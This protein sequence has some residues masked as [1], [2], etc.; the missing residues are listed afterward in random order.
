MAKETFPYGNDLNHPERWA[1]LANTKSESWLV[2]Y[3]KGA[4][5]IVGGHTFLFFGKES[6]VA[7]SA[8]FR[9]AGLTAGYGLSNITKRATRGGG[10][11]QRYPGSNQQHSDPAQVV[12]AFEHSRDAVNT[13]DWHYEKDD[14]GSAHQIYRTLAANVSG[15][16]AL[17]PFSS[18]D[19]NWTYGA[20]SGVSVEA[21]IG[22]GT[23]YLADASNLFTEARVI[24]I[25][26]EPTLLSAS[27]GSMQGFWFVDK[28]YSLWTERAY[29]KTEEYPFRA[30]SV[31]PYFHQW[32]SP[33]YAQAQ[34]LSRVQEQDRVLNDIKK[35]MME[36]PTK[37][38][39]PDSDY[40][41]QEIIK[42][43]E[44]LNQ[45]ARAPESNPYLPWIAAEHREVFGA[46]RWGPL[47]R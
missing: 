27:L 6:L 33:A 43:D 10:Q 4:S 19:L 26:Q 34:E 5:L 31:H 45:G 22:A 17:K 7:F 18:N 47:P 23:A 30:Y 21:V 32:K 36:N 39:Y 38:G 42:M 28:F 2:G 46:P 1:G 9:G 40:A 25:T 20:V 15:F 14:F 12:E 8:R 37:F 13:L 41:L 16:N 3:H 29:S 44:Q 11:T 35:E 24:N